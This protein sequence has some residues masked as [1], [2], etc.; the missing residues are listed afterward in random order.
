MKK[1][2]IKSIGEVGAPISISG[3]TLDAAITA[4]QVAIIK[5]SALGRVAGYKI[6][7]QK[8]EKPT[9]DNARHQH[10]LVVEWETTSYVN[11]KLN[12][13]PQKTVFEITDTT[14]HRIM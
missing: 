14:S 10:E 2:S 6:T 9:A 5:A 7:S 8:I 12:R 4:N 3:E 13:H 1:Y 11:D